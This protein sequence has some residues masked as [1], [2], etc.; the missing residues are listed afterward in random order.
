MGCIT[1]VVILFQYNIYLNI[2]WN[3]LVLVTFSPFPLAQEQNVRPSVKK[4][5]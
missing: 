3:V 5:Q 4:H 2:C 1:G